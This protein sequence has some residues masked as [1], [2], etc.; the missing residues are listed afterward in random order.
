MGGI[1]RAPLPQSSTAKGGAGRRR[2]FRLA[3]TSCRPTAAGQCRNSTGFP[4][5]PPVVAVQPHH[6][7][8]RESTILGQAPRRRLR[9]AT[10]Y[11]HGVA[12]VPS[13]DQLTRLP[14]VRLPLVGFDLASGVV[15][16]VVSGARR[17]LAIRMRS[18]VVG[19][20]PVR[21]ISLPLVGDPGLFGPDSVTWRIHADSSMFVGGV[22]ALLTQTMHPRVMAGVADHSAYRS[23]PLGRLNRTAGYVGLTT[24]GTIEQVDEVIAMVRRVHTTVVGTTPDGQPYEAN[25]PHLLSWVHHAL[26]DAFLRTYQRYGAAPLSAED[27]DR[28][29]AEMSVLAARLGCDATPASTGELDAYFAD[30][31]HELGAAGQARDAARW[32]LVPPLPLAVRPTYAVI[33]AAAIGL[34]PGWMRRQL[35][36]PLAPGV[37]P[38]VVRPATTAMLRTLDWV[39]AGH[40]PPPRADAPPPTSPAPE[41]MPG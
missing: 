40:P 27:A 3:D 21:D 20:T 32:L 12:R 38:V 22:L 23:D 36:L 2:A 17:D 13:L 29:V 4:Q 39:M 31:R 15:G 41:G 24:Y 7:R 37:D 30:V 8:A 14:V 19:D 5:R 25:D 11:R 35:W 6:T 9:P 10:A 33:T 28:Y 26:V 18:M 16:D 1:P 34:L